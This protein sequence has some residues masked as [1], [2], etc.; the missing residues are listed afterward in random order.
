MARASI[1]LGGNLGNVPVALRAAV[2]A[3][4][5][6]V[7]EVVAVSR[8][9][10][11]LPWGEPEQPEYLNAVALVD[12][13]LEPRRLLE[14]LQTIEKRLGR[15]PSYRW[16][17]RGID[18]DILTYDERRVAEPGLDIPHPRLLERAFALAPLA[19]VDPRYSRAYEA[20]ASG[21]RDAVRLAGPVVPWGE[22]QWLMSDVH[23]DPAGAESSLAAR[24]RA[25]A[26]AF[27]Q[28]DL[29]RLRIE[30]PNEDAV[31]FRKSVPFATP[32]TAATEAARDSAS[33]PANL[34]PIKSDLVGIVRF[35]RTA[36][37]EGEILAEDR[38]LAYVEALGIRNPVRSLG[39]GRLA[40][41][42][43]RDGQPV[44]YGQVLFEIDRG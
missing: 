28:T 19:E 3:I 21:E 29:V 20:L 31:E 8:L 5:R 25:L 42:R 6:D 44:E 18:L 15:V 17:P 33:A 11:S 37:A 39:A 1:G 23:Q 32:A 26:Q 2:R 24:V 40:T 35:S 12:T 14:A 27:V 13:S 22:T 9:Y 36:P 7:G 38:E 10:C 30:D 4:G 41:I 16:G 34:E 43:V